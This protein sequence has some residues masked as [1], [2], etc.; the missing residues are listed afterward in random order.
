MASPIRTAQ[1]IILIICFKR[2]LGQLQKHL[3]FKPRKYCPKDTKAAMVVAVAMPT[4][5]NGCISKIAKLRLVSRTTML[6]LTGD[7]VSPRA[8][9]LGA[10]AFTKT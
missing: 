10:K 9:K 3:L 5:P 1:I 6:Y 8:K 7:L 2:G 4:W